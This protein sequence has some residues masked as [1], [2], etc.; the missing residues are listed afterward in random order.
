MKYYLEED[1]VKSLQQVLKTFSKDA[2]SWYPRT[3]GMG[4]RG[5]VHSLCEI[6]FVYLK[7]YFN[8][9]RMTLLANP[10][11]CCQ[12]KKTATPLL[13]NATVIYY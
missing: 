11:H 7:D 1:R 3:R 12:N 4:Q 10:H 13:L 5:T 2:N 8:H 6:F 9:H